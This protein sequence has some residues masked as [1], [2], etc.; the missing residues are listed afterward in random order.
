MDTE[1][2]AVKCTSTVQSATRYPTIGDH[3]RKC[4]WVQL[5]PVSHT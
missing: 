5:H 1:L 4:Q 3:L 2:A